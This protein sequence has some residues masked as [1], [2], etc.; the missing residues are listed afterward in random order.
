MKATFT[1]TV[2]LIDDENYELFYDDSWLYSA[3]LE[4][5]L[6]CREGR[7][8]RREMTNLYHSTT[9]AHRYFKKVVQV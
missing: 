6:S 1:C 2:N 8:F 7:R 5:M 3:Q 4:T 9:L